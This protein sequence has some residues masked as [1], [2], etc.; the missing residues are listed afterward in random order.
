MA[1]IRLTVGMNRWHLPLDT[2][3]EELKAAVFNAMR[4]DKGDWISIK[5]TNTLVDIYISSGVP[6][7]IQP[8]VGVNVDQI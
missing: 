5:T 2:D 1:S 8:V 3:V 6:I 7:S 4:F